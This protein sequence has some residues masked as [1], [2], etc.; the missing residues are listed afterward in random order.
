MVGIQI[1]PGIDHPETA[2]R[3]LLP[4][5]SVLLS[6]SFFL[7]SLMPLASYGRPSATGASS[8][9]V[10]FVQMLFSRLVGWRPDTTLLGNI[11]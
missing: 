1:L 10:D 9:V 2:T 6:L 3:K 4:V 5:R 11:S 7:E 8:V